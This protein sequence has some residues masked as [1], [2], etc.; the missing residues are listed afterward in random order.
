MLSIA[1]V[2]E[3]QTSTTALYDGIL[4]DFVM[5]NMDGPTATKALRAMGYNGVIIGVT[6]NQLSA[7][8]E[9]F[10]ECGANKV[11]M[12]PLVVEQFRQV[13]APTYSL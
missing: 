13:A 10:L 11:L 3:K 4:M 1:K 5:P 8:I 12:K 9:H 7:D 2:L 6:G